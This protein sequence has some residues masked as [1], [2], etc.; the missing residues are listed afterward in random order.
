MKKLFSE[1]M[2]QPIPRVKEAL[3]EV[4]RTA[5]LQLIEL[6]I[7]DNSFGLLLPPQ[8]CTPAHATKANGI[9][10]ATD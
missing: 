1:R 2:G 8:I 4:V 3:D 5:L 9:L 10:A 6:R 7:N